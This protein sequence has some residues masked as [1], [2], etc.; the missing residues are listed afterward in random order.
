VCF[1]NKKEYLNSNWKSSIKYEFY[2]KLLY[3][4]KRKIILLFFLKYF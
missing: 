2:F 4:K 1:Y 3:P